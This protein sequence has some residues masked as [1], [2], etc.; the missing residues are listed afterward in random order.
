MKLDNY[1][2]VSGMPGIFELVATRNNG[3]MLTDMDSSKTRFFSVRKHQFTPLG[4]VA[5]YTFN[6]AT[7]LSTIFRTMNDQAE[8]NPII[9][10]SAAS[11]DIYAYFEKILPDFDRDRV[12]ISDIKKVIKWYNF[13]LEREKLDFSIS[14]EEE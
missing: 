14:D 3:L 11:K 1:I 13:L 8:S 4:S 10:T 2:A 5:I 7:E 6:D 9:S 12:F